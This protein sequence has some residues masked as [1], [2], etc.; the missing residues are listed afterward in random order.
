MYTALHDQHL[1]LRKTRS[2]IWSD[3]DLE[4]GIL[5]QA[6]GANQEALAIVCQS[7]I[8]LDGIGKDPNLWGKPDE[9]LGVSPAACSRPSG[10][11]ANRDAS[12]G[13]GGHRCCVSTSVQ[14]AQEQE[15][16]PGA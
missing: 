3:D 5:G 6:H 8:G 15:G 10:A 11:G 7:N 9:R 12:T 2:F 1:G 13:P 4:V 16:E 14:D